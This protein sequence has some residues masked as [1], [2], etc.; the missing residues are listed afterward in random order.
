VTTE[1]AVGA[2]GLVVK[3]RE[4]RDHEDV[5]L[6]TGCRVWSAARLLGD[7]LAAD[8]DGATD[9]GNG[10]S[11]GDSG[12]GSG[13]SG[14]GSGGSGGGSGGGGGGV[15]GEAPADMIK[16]CDVLELGAGTGAVGLVCAALGARSVTLTARLST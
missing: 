7:Y 1:V 9:A 11:G 14:G 2:G 6:R 13:G 3:L 15:S 16:G 12:G 8:A 4:E 5:P 10:D